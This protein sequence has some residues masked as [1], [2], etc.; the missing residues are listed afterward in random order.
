ME[1]LELPKDASG[2]VRR[3]CPGC[4]RHFKT[5]PHRAD[6]GAALR[7]L[8]SHLDGVNA[9]ELDPELEMWRCPYCGQGFPADNWLTVEQCAL[10]ERVA[11]DV[12]QHV[13]HEQLAHVSRTLGVNPG[14]TFVLVKPA[15]LELEAPLDPDDLQRFPLVC[16]ADE[17][18]VDPVWLQP[19]TCPRCGAEHPRGAPVVP[20]E[21]DTV[22]A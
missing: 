5:R 13:Q 9:E 1:S 11:A 12:A 20:Y 19:L 15:P 3:E 22:N 10:I 7:E 4:R 6:A 18:K 8:A 21:G 16:C 17:V 14:P 2:F